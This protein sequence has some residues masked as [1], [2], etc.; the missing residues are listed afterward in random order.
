MSFGQW[1]YSKKNIAGCALAA[2]GAP[3]LLLTG[4]VAPP[5]ALALVPALY[6]IGALIAPSDKKESVTFTNAL[7]KVEADDVEQSL[8]VIQESIQG[9][10]GPEVGSRVTRIVAVID[11]LLPK[12]SK[13]GKSS[14]E[15]RILIRTATDYLPNTLKPYLAM[16]RNYAE[17][18]VISDGKTAEGL[19]CDQL[20]LLYNGL[21]GVLE[22]VA[23]N[24]AD[25]LLSNGLF[26]KEKFG[27]SSLTLGA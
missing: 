5:L 19:L 25:A 4:V 18:K 6:G 20:D 1:L 7:S 3:T 15:M 16:P 2:V 22:A 26:L 13:L 23:K 9:N 8:A 21:Q 27:T 11:M 14:N 17:H 12:A 10:V 24:D